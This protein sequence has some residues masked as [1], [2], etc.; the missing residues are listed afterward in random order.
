MRRTIN[1]LGHRQRERAK[2]HREPDALFLQWLPLTIEPIFGAIVIEDEFVDINQIG[3]I[4]G[5]GPAQIA[6]MAQQDKGRPGEERTGHIQP[7][8]RM[9]NC[10]IPR[11]LA[12]KGLV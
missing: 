1:G 5:I 10:F 4:D 7:L 11:H 8:A 9:D 2:A 12:F 3:P 6:V